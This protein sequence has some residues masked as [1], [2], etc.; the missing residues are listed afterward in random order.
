MRISAHAPRAPGREGLQ[1]RAQPPGGVE[2]LLRLVTAQPVLQLLR[3]GRVAMHARQRYLV[4]APEPFT[5]WPSTSLGPVQPFGLRS[6]I[7]GQRGRVGVPLAR[8]ACWS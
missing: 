3:M 2:Q 5:L 4:G 6:T 7:M 8:A 1:F